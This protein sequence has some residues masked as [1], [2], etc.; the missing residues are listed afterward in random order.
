MKRVLIIDD[1]IQ[2]CDVLQM[3]LST[4]GYR[5]E[6]ALNGVSGFAKAIE[7]LPHLIILDVNMPFMDGLSLLQEIKWHPD[8]AHIPIL[9]LSGGLSN[10]DL[11]KE[12]GVDGF[13]AKPYQ[14]EE[15]LHMVEA[16]MVSP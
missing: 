2:M 13:I 1:D 4:Q 3:R 14:A 5:V 8:I 7:F 9:I 12:K 6:I 16:C 10:K 15:L 11:F